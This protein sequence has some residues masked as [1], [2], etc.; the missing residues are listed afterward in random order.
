MLDA[1]SKGS[2]GVGVLMLIGTVFWGLL[3]LGSVYTIKQAHGYVVFISS[4]VPL[5]RSLCNT[6]CISR[7]SYLII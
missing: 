4:A 6:A 5:F 3:V 2:A 1:F 7:L